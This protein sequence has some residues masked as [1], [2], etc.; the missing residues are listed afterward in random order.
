MNRRQFTLATGAVGFAGLAGCLS[1]DDDTSVQSGDGPESIVDEYFQTAQ[2]CQS[3]LQDELIHSEATSEQGLVENVETTVVEEDLEPAA[4]AARAHTAYASLTDL[5]TETAESIAAA[6][7]T[8]I[9]EATITY[10]DQGG[11]DTDTIQWAVATEGGDWKLVS[12]ARDDSD[13]G[14]RQENQAP[15][16]NFRLDYQADEGTVTITHTSGD[17]VQAQNLFV[18]GQNIESGHTGAWHEIE[19]SEYEPADELSAGDV[20]DIQVEDGTYVINVVWESPEG[21]ESVVLAVD[22][23]PDS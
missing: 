1:S 11:S 13:S 17:T 16:T 23:G 21:D 5:D 12:Q 2:E 4:F 18:R 19:G 10:A 14:G 3:T 6:G 7:E 9:V 20:V 15:N 8:A 22:E